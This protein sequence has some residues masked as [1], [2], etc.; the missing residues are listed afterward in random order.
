ML[1]RLILL[2]DYKVVCIFSMIKYSQ[3]SNTTLAWEYLK[4][5]WFALKSGFVWNLVECIFI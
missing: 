2:G 3:D 1:L 5:S 4:A